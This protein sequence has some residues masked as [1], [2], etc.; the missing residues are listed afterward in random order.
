MTSHQLLNKKNYKLFYVIGFVFAINLHA[1]SIDYLFKDRINFKIQNMKLEPSI[2][3]G[4]SENKIATDT[5]V[6]ISSQFS[7]T[8]GP[9]V[10]KKGNIFF[11]DQ[12]N[13]QI[14]KYGIDGKLSLFMNNT[15]R[16][17]GM[18][19][20]NKGNLISCADEHNELIEISPSKKIKVLANNF[21]GKIFN[22]PNDVWVN[23][24][25][26]DIYFTDPYYKRDYWNNN[27]PHIEEQN[28]YYLAKNKSNP[29]AA[30]TQL[31][32][33]N[34]II[35]TPDGKFLFIADI[36]ANK[37]YK[38]SI[39][40]NGSLVNK[41]LFANQGSDGMTIDNKGNIYL[42]GKGVTVYNKIGKMIQQIPIPEDWT[43]NVCF[44]GKN[45]DELFITAS[46]SVYIL[47]TNVKGVQ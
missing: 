32:K 20:D 33:P 46:K 47:H 19:F 25:K 26:G 31:T 23:P 24:A 13:N 7:F 44:G 9:A 17:N 28:V 39:N 30:E 18:Y 8:E 27:H 16:S 15:G 34:G 37:T 22:G 21:N 14:W 45:M 41:Q 4:I 1:Y 40:D 38:Y 11:T 42:T 6:L 29:L 43:A 10:D 35:G 12:P 36:G 2:D 5:P 3:T